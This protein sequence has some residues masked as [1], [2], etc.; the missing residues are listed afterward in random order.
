MKI[1]STNRHLITS[2][3]EGN[4]MIIDF[5]ENQ[6]IRQFTLGFGFMKISI[7]QNNICFLSKER[8]LFFY[9]LASGK[10]S[11]SIQSEDNQPFS[12]FG[13]LDSNLNSLVLA[14]F[15]GSLYGYDTSNL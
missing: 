9:D 8:K 6:I 10:R 2:D 11:S 15:D 7:V 1:D 14:G 13:Q 12:S 4:I 5:L 3:P